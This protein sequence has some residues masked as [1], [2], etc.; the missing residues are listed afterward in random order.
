[1]QK[2]LEIKSYL[3]VGSIFFGMSQQDVETLF[4]KEPDKVKK[5][6]SGKLGMYWDNIVV[7]LNHVNQVDEVSFVSGGNYNVSYCGI[8]LLQ[9]AHAKEKMD[10]IELPKSVV[11][12]HVYFSLG[13]AVT[14]FSEDNTCK[15]VTVFD[16]SLITTWEK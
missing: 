14:G 5:G 3:S 13:I 4:S 16:K 11:G 2:I 10:L 12:F 9:D 8:D 1:M 7:K 15:T 6:F